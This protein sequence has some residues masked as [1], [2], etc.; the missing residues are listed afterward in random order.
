MIHG[1]MKNSPM[2]SP[3]TRPAPGDAMPAMPKMWRIM[4][5]TSSIATAERTKG[6]GLLPLGLPVSSHSMPVAASHAFDRVMY[7]TAPRIHPVAAATITA[8]SPIAETSR[9]DVSDAE[10]LPD[11]HGCA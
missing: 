5:A 9:S 11:R 6:R 2:P 1:E 10:T 4:P 3:A 8:N 7:H